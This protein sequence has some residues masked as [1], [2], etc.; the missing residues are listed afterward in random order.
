VPTFGSFELLRAAASTPTGGSL[1]LEDV[2]VADTGETTAFALERFEV[3]ASDATITVHGDGGL[4]TV[5]PAPKNSYFRGTV[6]GEPGSR[7]VLA[8]LAD[9]T[10]QGI[11][12]RAGD[13][14]FIG[15]DETPVKASGLPLE[16]R[17][18][19]PSLLKASRGEGFACS[20][21]D[22]PKSPH[23]L[24]NLVLAGST[25]AAPAVAATGPVTAR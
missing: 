25:S 4:S 13:T 23:P 3:F 5:L 16:M 17:R 11:V 14:Y 21:A 20:N 8:V 9:A 19:A 24:E 15:G 7:V 10:V 22:L 6:E 12:T 1:R 2:Q 18:V